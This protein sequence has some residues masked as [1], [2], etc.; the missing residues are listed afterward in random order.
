MKDKRKYFMKQ[1]N[2]QNECVCDYKNE[3]HE[4]NIGDVNELNI[5]MKTNTLH[6]AQNL[7]I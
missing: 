4:Q 3:S 7:K 1:Y 2:K 5:S 6:A